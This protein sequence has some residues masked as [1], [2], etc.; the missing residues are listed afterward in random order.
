MSQYWSASCRTRG[1]SRGSKPRS[2]PEIGEQGDAEVPK[3]TTRC[4]GTEQKVLRAVRV[5][6]QLGGASTHRRCAQQL[7]LLRRVSRQLSRHRRGI[8]Q[9][10]LALPPPAA[11]KQRKFSG[12][13]WSYASCYRCRQSCC[14]DGM[15]VPSPLRVP[16]VMRCGRPAGIR[17][18]QRGIGVEGH[19]SGHRV[20]GGAAAEEEEGQEE[21]QQ[22]A[23]KQQ[24]ALQEL[25]VSR[26]P[27][28]KWF[29]SS[30]LA[31]RGIT[32]GQCTISA[33]PQRRE[34][35]VLHNFNVV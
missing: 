18:G 35:K 13:G 10:L 19:H 33:V 24:Q 32:G 7:K 14:C 30:Q 31:A 16:A 34:D 3:C 12:S 25:G 8:W 28:T 1:G 21:Q 22:Q 29:V 23:A 2:Q 27:R 20:G 9:P 6:E 4:S 17:G 15:Q 5:V 11:S 26:L